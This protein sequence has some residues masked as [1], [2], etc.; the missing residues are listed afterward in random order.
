MVVFRIVS[1]DGDIVY[2][3]TD[4]LEMDEVKREKMGGY[5]WKIEENMLNT[6]NF[7]SRIRPQNII[8]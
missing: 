6:L 4:V 1:K 3:A 7:A 2:W 5:S 8:T